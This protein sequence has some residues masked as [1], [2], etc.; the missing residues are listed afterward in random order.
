MILCCILAAG[1]AHPGLG[2][3]AR[4][5]DDDGDVQE[6]ELTDDEKDDQ[7]EQA[8][9]ADDLDTLAKFFESGG[10]ERAPAGASG[11]MGDGPLASASVAL[12]DQVAQIS[13]F[14]TP[15]TPTGEVK[16]CPFRPSVATLDGAPKLDGARGTNADPTTGTASGAK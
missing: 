15:T 7:I 4:A 3:A 14:L 1:M 8:E 13:A 11:V 2:T 9:T 10:E 6:R 5:A 16:F 12:P